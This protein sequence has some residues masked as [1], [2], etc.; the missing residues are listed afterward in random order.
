LLRDTYIS[1]LD[2]IKPWIFLNTDDL[3]FIDYFYS[4]FG[5]QDLLL[6]TLGILLYRQIRKNE[7]KTIKFIGG[8]VFLML[9]LFFFPDFSA[10]F[11][12]QRVLYFVKKNGDIIDGFNL[13][14]VWLRFPLYWFYGILIVTINKIIKNKQAKQYK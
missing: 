5:I 7:N 8:S 2:K 14:Y 4:F 13:A 3:D 10:T 6:L 1:L 11:E 12:A 9:F